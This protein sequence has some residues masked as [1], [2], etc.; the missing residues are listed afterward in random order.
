MRN[1]RDI[2][3]ELLDHVTGMHPQGEAVWAVV[4]RFSMLGEKNRSP[5][6]LKVAFETIRSKA[7][8]IGTE[9]RLYMLSN[10]DTVLLS[11]L[12]KKEALTAIEEEVRLLF[13]DDIICSNTQNQFIEYFD[14]SCEYKRFLLLC[15]QY[16]NQ[17]QVEKELRGNAVR[18]QKA[19]AS[20]FTMD[21][22]KKAQAQWEEA[23]KTREVRDYSVVLVI[24]DDRLIP[25][26]VNDSIPRDMSFLS[27]STATDG[28]MKYASNAPDVVFMDIGL[29]DSDGLTAIQEFL[30]LDKK[31][32][33]IML[34]A[35]QEMET[36][37]QAIQRGASGYLTKPFTRNHIMKYINQYTGHEKE[38]KKA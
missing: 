28:Y 15:N 27:S 19:V 23:V 4:F 36:I 30:S 24:D 21:V 11:R 3:Q 34:T 16:M 32:R 14:L 33:I 10:K 35:D 26:L 37:N 22:R 38:N 18:G 17:K 9:S 1:K 2:E 13:A 25:T 5:E 12:A 20:G 7:S 29:P 8:V 31:A 6:A